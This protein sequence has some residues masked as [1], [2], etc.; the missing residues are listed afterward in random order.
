MADIAS[1]LDATLRA[2]GI[3]IIGV[4][5]GVVA[6]RTT[7]Q[8]QYADTATDPQKAQGESIRATFDVN[9]PAVTSAQLDRDADTALASA[10]AT[11]ALVLDSELGRALTAAD[12]P[13][14]RAKFAKYRTYYKFIVNN[15]L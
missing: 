12:G 11:C 2:A 6:D 15:G 7:W 8:V 13:A 4:S 14:V 10:K 3:P 1:L 9:A 5:I